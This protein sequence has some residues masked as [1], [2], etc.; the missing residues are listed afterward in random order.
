MKSLHRVSRLL[1]LGALVSVMPSVPA[2]AA[3][4]MGDQV[5]VNSGQLKWVDA[6]PSLPK[7][8]K[9]AVL[10]GDPSKAGQVVVRLK[11]PAGYRVPPHWHSQTE[12]L[13]VISGALYLGMGD[14][15]EPAQAHALK[16]GGFHY[17]PG[18]THHYA[19]TRT[20]TVVQIHGEGPLDITYINPEDNPQKQAAK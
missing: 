7:G 1:A 12:N 8:A 14:K 5:F 20:P 4:P 6:P 13:T 3:D 17:L 18:K 10:Y 11:T 16:A 9:V 19:F 2:L 15:M